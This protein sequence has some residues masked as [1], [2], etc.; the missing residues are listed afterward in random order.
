LAPA[1]RR[2][3]RA[4]DPSLPVPTVVTAGQRLGQ[5]LGIRR[6]QTQALV[7]FAG[8]ALAFAAA[9]LY[10]ALTY[11]VT[12]RR[13]EIG[14][15]TALGAGRRDI[16]GLFVRGGAALTLA[17]T[18]IGIAGAI[19]TAQVVRSLLYETAPLDL[20]SYLAAAAA[21]T[22]VSMMAAAVPAR[23]ASRVDPLIILREG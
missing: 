19:L 2:E 20:R 7:F 1:I 13:R 3:L 17:G 8:V 5:Q 18:A 15:R 9:G 10:A 16:V 11:Q 12:L 4:L 23:R 21:V 22:V 14:I 6:F